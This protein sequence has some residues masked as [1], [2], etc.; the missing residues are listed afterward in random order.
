MVANQATPNWLVAD[1]NTR[2]V[3]LSVAAPAAG[4]VTSV[5]R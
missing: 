2:R 5:S 4:C 3:K 1:L